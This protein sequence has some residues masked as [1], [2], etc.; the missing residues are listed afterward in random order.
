MSSIARPFFVDKFIARRTFYR[1]HQLPGPRAYSPFPGREFDFVRT[2]HVRDSLLSSAERDT[3]AGVF[4]GVLFP[5]LIPSNRSFYENTSR[6]RR[7]FEQNGK[8]PDTV[9]AYRT[10]RIDIFKIFVLIYS[11]C[12]IG[13]HQCRGFFFFN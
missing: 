3:R 12:S 1:H 13:V 4:V 5:V 2:G 11:C 10:I 6:H 8:R 7:F 9:Y